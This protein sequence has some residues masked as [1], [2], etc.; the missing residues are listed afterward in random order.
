M[1]GI[2]LTLFGGGL[3]GSFLTAG[4][5]H[6][7]TRLQHMNCYYIDDDVLSK[8]PQVREDNTIHQNVHCKKFKIKN[9]TN[10]DIAEFKILFQF[11][12]T[13]EIIECYSHSKEGWNRQRVRKSKDDNNQAE[14]LV[15]NFNRGDE[16]EY[17]FHVANI[18][19]N[20]YYVTECNCIG[21]KI[22]CIDKCKVAKK[23]KA[24]RSDQV[25]V[26]KH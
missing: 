22:K 17:T 3:A 23:N 7:K 4:I 12:P 13:A 18:T 15:R 8:I 19:D 2:L 11:D 14:A 10:K 21:F 16:I 25:L 1:T 9:T 5:N 6:V 26:V 20:K 24:K